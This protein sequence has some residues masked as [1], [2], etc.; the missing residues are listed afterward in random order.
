MNDIN[1]LFICYM[2][3]FKFCT[4]ILDLLACKTLASVCTG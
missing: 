1:S 4:N 2:V 3:V